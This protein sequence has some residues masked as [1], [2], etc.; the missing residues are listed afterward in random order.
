M[1]IQKGPAGLYPHTPSHHLAWPHHAVLIQ[2]IL[3]SETFQRQS[4]RKSRKRK[5][6]FY[7]RG[8]CAITILG[9]LS[10]ASYEQFDVS[11]AVKSISLL[12]GTSTHA[13]AEYATTG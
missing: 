10:D 6:Y 2:L 1:I 13:S 12:A 9:N 8:Q 7:N 3:Q 11:R 5:Q 4:R